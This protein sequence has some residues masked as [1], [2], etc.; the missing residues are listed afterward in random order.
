[1]EVEEPRR[2]RPCLKQS[3]SF[4][5]VFTMN[6]ALQLWGGTW[7]LALA[8]RDR[9]RTT[10]MG[11]TREEAVQQASSE[12]AVSLSLAC[13]EMPV[14]TSSHPVC[15]HRVCVHTC[16]VSIVLST[17]TLHTFR[18][19]PG[20]HGVIRSTNELAT[21]PLL[22]PARMSCD[23]IGLCWFAAVLA[24]SLDSVACNLRATDRT[25]L[26]CAGCRCFHTGSQAPGPPFLPQEF[27]FFLTQVTFQPH[28]L[29]RSSPAAQ[30]IWAPVGAIV[31]AAR[32]GGSL[33]FLRAV[34]VFCV[35]SPP[36]LKDMV[37]G[38]PSHRVGIEL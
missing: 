36:N 5:V 11:W 29:S 27:R 34:L 25:G 26:G 8:T 24:S 1:M 14:N 30:R 12:C 38:D 28:P 37:K 31:L 18:N 3:P 13:V 4:L 15:T 17:W 6:S 21:V 22:H 33:H 35:P 9:I 2:S 23:R 16:P 20:E 10:G 7:R 19:C 32:E